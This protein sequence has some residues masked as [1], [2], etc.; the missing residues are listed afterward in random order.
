MKKL[1]NWNYELTRWEVIA[2]EYD[3][4]KLNALERWW[5]DNWEWYWEEPWDSIS[6]IEKEF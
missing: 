2:Y 6:D 1:D 3:S 4:R 5:V